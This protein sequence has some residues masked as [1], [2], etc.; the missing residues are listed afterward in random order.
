MEKEK[1]KKL[2]V[3]LGLKKKNQW[4]K[5]CKHFF[6]VMVSVQGDTV[7]EKQKF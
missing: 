4:T 1:K 7:R 3:G 6:K 2:S 5:N